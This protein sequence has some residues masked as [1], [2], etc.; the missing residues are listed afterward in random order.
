MARWPWDPDTLQDPRKWQIKYEKDVQNLV[1]LVLRSYF[2]DL[3]DEE[4]L[5]KFGN[6]GYRADFGIPTLG[7]LIEVKFVT[8]QGDFDRATKEVMEDS[9]AYLHDTSPYDRL[10]VFI[11]DDS[12]SVQ[13]HAAVQATLQKIPDIS[14]VIIVSRPSQLPAGASLRVRGASG[15][16]S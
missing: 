8:S 9:I 12:A 11:Y 2:T 7:L 16:S 15:R 6:R 3:I 5:P 14:E 10:L 4:A 13:V 1:W